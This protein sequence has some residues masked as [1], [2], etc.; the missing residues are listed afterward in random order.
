MDILVH[1]TLPALQECQKLG[2]I[3]AIGITGYDLALH[4]QLTEAAF[5]ANIPVQSCL[6]YCHY[7]LNDTTLV[8]SGFMQWAMARGCL[9][10]NGSALGMGLFSQ[11]GPA[12][13]HP[14]SSTQRQAAHL[15]AEVAKHRGHDIST[16]ALRCAMSCPDVASVMFSTAKLSE[17]HDTLRVA[18]TEPAQDE[19]DTMKEIMSTVLSQEGQGGSIGW[20]GVEVSKYWQKLGRAAACDGVYA[21][22]ITCDASSR[23]YAFDQTRTDANA[24]EP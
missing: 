9:V 15:A 20:G 2:K 3:K 18:T 12:S 22:G 8:S 14:A 17:L 6:T 7:T 5:H 24:R 19:L 13:W 10:Y 11:G 16:L 4:R 1:E 23:L 21:R